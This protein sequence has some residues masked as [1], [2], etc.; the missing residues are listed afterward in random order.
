MRICLNICEP[1][2]PGWML[3]LGMAGVEEQERGPDKMD[4][5]GKKKHVNSDLEHS[6]IMN[7]SDIQGFVMLGVGNMFTI[8]SYPQ[9]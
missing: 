1:Q 4:K 5:E 3:P 2:V 6:N 9:A 8:H 7:V